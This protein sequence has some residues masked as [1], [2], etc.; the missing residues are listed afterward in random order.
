M[1]LNLTG[2]LP[3]SV[4]PYRRFLLPAVLLFVLLLVV[5]MPARV[6]MAFVDVTQFGVYMQGVSGPWYAAHAARV[7]VVTPELAVD[8]GNLKWRVQPLAMLRGRLMLALQAEFAQRPVEA[9][10]GAGIGGRV[11]AQQVRAALPLNEFAP[12]MTNLL[13]PVDGQINLQDIS[14]E[15][16]QQWPV[17]LT[18][19]VLL[20]NMT[21]TTPVQLLEV[22]DV[23]LGLEMEDNDVVVPIIENSGQL[24][25]GGRLTLSEEHRFGLLLTS[26]PSDQLSR[27]LQAQMQAMLGRPDNGQFSLRY[28]G[29]W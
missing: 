8:L 18:G 21:V 22:G 28:D 12:L 6:L 9:T 26:T 23:L 19:K 25:L 29:A 10:V 3:K 27:E 1:A 7:R 15:L 11:Y 24:G 13:F 2:R 14:L 5:T 4:Q 20:A 16:K 17:Q